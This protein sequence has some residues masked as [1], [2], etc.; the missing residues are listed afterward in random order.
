MDDE[1]AEGNGE[2]VVCLG[3]PTCLFQGDEAVE[4]QIDGCPN[5]RRIF[6]L[7]DGTEC[8]YRRMTH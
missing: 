2:I 5:C 1:D 7:S 8:E 3:P 6:Y 4:N